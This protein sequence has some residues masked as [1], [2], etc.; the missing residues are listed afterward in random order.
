[1]RSPERPRRFVSDGR[2]GGYWTYQTV[3]GEAEQDRLAKEQRAAQLAQSLAWHPA[4]AAARQ[5]EREAAQQQA[6][7]R[8]WPD[9]RAALREAHGRLREVEATLAKLR[10][11]ATAAAEHTARCEDE[12]KRSSEA[13]E[14]IR[15]AQA[16]RL[17]ERLAGNGDTS[18]DDDDPAHAEVLSTVDRADR[19]LSVALTAQAD[20][21]ASVKQAEDEVGR[22]KQQVEVAAAAVIEKTRQ[23][24]EA[25]W[26]AAQQR[27]AD[28]QTRMVELRVDQRYS[29]ANWKAP[30]RALLTDPEAVV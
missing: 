3:E 26:T 16:A 21:E 11:H 27:A 4:V 6:F 15:T 30:L 8:Q 20:I 19:A 24:V 1:V 10:Q 14:E 17:R 25:E 22:A 7:D 5:A 28:L 23:A 29:S 13:A 9:P 18:P 12:V 2:G